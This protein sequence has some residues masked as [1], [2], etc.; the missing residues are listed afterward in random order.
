MKQPENLIARP[1]R[2][3]QAMLRVIARAEPEVLPVVPDG[4]YG[5]D[6][7]AS[8]RSF[9][10][11]HGL[12]ATGEADGATWNAVVEDYTRCAAAVLPACPLRIRWEPLQVLHPGDRNLHLF[13]IQGMLLALGRVYSPVPEVR[14]TGVYDEATQRAIAWLLEKS[15]L[16]EE[17]RIDQ[18]VWEYLCGLYC[19]SVGNG[20]SPCPA[21]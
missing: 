1:V 19:L 7:A 16:P 9:Q 20:E 2:S 4:I 6:T 10:S 13:L 17:N 11:S 3:L 12:N 5:E 15:D 8:V 18:T 21:P 14:A